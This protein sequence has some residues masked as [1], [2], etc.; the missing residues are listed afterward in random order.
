VESAGLVLS[1]CSGRFQPLRGGDQI[2][3]YLQVDICDIFT[4]SIL[5][6]LSF[7]TLGTNKSSIRIYP[8]PSPWI[9]S[10]DTS[11]AILCV[12]VWYCYL[13]FKTIFGLQDPP[14]LGVLRLA[15]HV[16]SGQAYQL[17]K[18][19]N[20]RCVRVQTL[21]LL[22]WEAAV[23]LCGPCA[24][25]RCEPAEVA[26][27]GPQWDVIYCLLPPLLPAWCDVMCLCGSRFMSYS[28]YGS[29]MKHTDSTFGRPLRSYVNCL[30]ESVAALI[31]NMSATPHHI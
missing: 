19:H 12:V 17:C 9:E 18:F 1:S 13:P 27:P 29:V 28:A 23:R 4:E 5:W 2:A 6:V 7:A 3:D 8:M 10:T 25:L 26:G 31:D 22:P 14:Q 21:Q 11:N 16:R 30:L 20:W 15:G 24:Y